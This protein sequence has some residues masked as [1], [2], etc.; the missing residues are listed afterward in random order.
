MTAESPEEE[1][2]G[3]CADC[4]APVDEGADPAFPFGAAS[5]LCFAC[6]VRRGGAFDA[7][8]DRWMKQPDLT[9]LARTG[10]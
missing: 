5:V 6:A 2:L 10:D 4:G 1:Q 8:K 7:F 9:G 3:E